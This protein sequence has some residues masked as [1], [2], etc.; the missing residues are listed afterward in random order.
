MRWG[1]EG[2]CGADL[3]LTT[4]TL[5]RVEVYVSS[6]IAVRL[7]DAPSQNR[8]ISAWFRAASHES[9]VAP[10][11]TYGIGANRQFSCTHFDAVD[12]LHPR[13]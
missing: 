9:N 10:P 6:A 2:L 8:S 1:R 11:R 13:V 4:H 7:R 12:V 5:Y 3:I